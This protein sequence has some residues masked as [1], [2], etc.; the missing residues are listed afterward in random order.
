MR[1]QSVYPVQQASSLLNCN[2]YSWIACRYLLVSSLVRNPP[3]WQESL[4]MHMLA[5]VYMGNAKL[6]KLLGN[7]QAQRI[8]S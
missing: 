6:E 3:S 2:L 7:L 5:A 4:H 8:Y 1:A